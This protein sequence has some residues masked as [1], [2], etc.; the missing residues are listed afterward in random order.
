MN[1]FYDTW[2]MAKRSLRHTIR[3]MDTI[4]TVV[5]TPIAMMLLFVYVFGTSFSQATGSIKYVDF[6][7]PTIII[8]TVVS[9]I[10]Y[11]A[12]RLSTDMRRGS[13]IV[14]KLCRLRHPQF[15]A[16]MRYRR[17]Y[18]TYSHRF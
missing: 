3:S 12:F 10:A 13:S 17:R 1:S 18:P 5:A 11:A 14:S 8:M 16:A 15:W 4:I 2:V 6:I 9:G 7:A